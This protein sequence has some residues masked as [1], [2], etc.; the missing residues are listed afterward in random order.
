MITPWYILKLNTISW[1]CQV[2]KTLMF[3]LRPVSIPLNQQ[4]L[5]YDLSVLYDRHFCVLSI[6]SFERGLQY[7]FQRGRKII[8]FTNTSDL[9]LYHPY[10][11]LP[12]TFWPRVQSQN[13]ND[14][15]EQISKWYI[16]KR[17][18]TKFMNKH[19][20]TISFQ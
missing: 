20:L 6:W 15:L 12:G 17:F 11:P 18:N 8:I 13:W 3:P 5:N 16:F 10:V 4:T 2:P 19:N 7:Q 1:L 14:S 9:L